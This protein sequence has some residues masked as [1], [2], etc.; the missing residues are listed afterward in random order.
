MCLLE[1]AFFYIHKMSASQQQELYTAETIFW[2]SSVL[3]APQFTALVT[4]DEWTQ[5]VQ[6]IRDDV[7]IYPYNYQQ[8][9]LEHF[10][11]RVTLLRSSS[12]LRACAYLGSDHIAVKEDK[13]WRLCKVAVSSTCLK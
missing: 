1:Q 4:V 9:S 13:P 2:G 6:I 11:P 7:Q 3:D 8:S 10:V 12:T 5:F